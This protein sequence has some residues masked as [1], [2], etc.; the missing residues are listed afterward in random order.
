MTDLTHY[1]KLRDKAGELIILHRALN[2][3]L[4]KDPEVH[5]ILY[6][7]KIVLEFYD[8]K[9]LRKLRKVIKESIYP[10]WTDTIRNVWQGPSLS[11][12]LTAWHSK[13]YP[14]IQFWL[15][16]PVGE[17]PKSLLKP[18]CKIVT[19]TVEGTT[20]SLVCEA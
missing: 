15:E 8:L 16:C 20:S 6:E 18:G 3:R 12:M 13:Q 5:F 1:E 11:T 7:G 10:D 2:N 4:G 19:E 17:Y 9:V 14:L